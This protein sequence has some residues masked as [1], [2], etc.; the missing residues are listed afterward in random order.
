METPKT[1]E[2]FPRTEFQAKLV[3][4]C[5]VLLVVGAFGIMIFF[6]VSR[7]ILAD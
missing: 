6:G 3:I 7:K 2:M 1:R 5:T 4:A